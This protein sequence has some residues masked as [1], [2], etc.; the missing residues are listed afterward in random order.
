MHP[1]DVKDIL[2]QAVFT[3]DLSLNAQVHKFSDPTTA[4]FQHSNNYLN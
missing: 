1:L 2:Q 3:D 4:T